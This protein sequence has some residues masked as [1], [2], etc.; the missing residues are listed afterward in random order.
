MRSLKYLFYCL[1]F[2]SI[3]SLTAAAGA[4]TYNQSNEFNTLSLMDPR[5]APNRGPW[6]EGWYTRIYDPLTKN[7]FAII[8]ASQKLKNEF[9]LADAPQSGYIAVL[10]STAAGKTQSIELFPSDTMMYS[11]GG[12]VTQQSNFGADT[13]FMWVSEK[14]GYVSQDEI[15][16][17]LGEIK[18]DVN[19]SDRKAWS[20]AINGNWGPEGFGNFIPGFPLHWFVYSLGSQTSYNIKIANDT[21]KGTGY[22][23]QEKNWGKVFPKSWIWLQG[24][25]DDNSSAIAIAGGIVDLKISQVTAWLAGYRSRNFNTSFHPGQIDVYYIY[26]TD[27]CRGIFEIEIKNGDYELRV[28]AKADPASFAPV[29]IPT[30]T[31]YKSNAGKESFRAEIEVS[32]YEHSWLQNKLGPLLER[33]KYTNSALEFGADYMKCP[34]PQQ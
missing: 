17:N 23:H 5:V 14:Y 28:K 31:S 34:A 6:F 32:L 30:E 7:S 33:T 26:R 25:S 21:F 29:S 16:L 2:L 4:Q 20:P 18:I 12:L 11:H 9:I 8:V 10:Y 15:K 22:S 3:L 27:S 19:M 1:F 13:D 24:V